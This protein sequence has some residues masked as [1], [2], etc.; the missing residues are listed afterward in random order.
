MERNSIGGS[1]PESIHGSSRNIL[2][3]VTNK[4]GSLFKGSTQ[5]SSNSSI[6]THS[7]D[8]NGPSLFASPSPIP[9]QLAPYGPGSPALPPQPF[10]SSTEPVPLQHPGHPSHASLPTLALSSGGPPSYAPSYAPQESHPNS[11]YNFPARMSS[12]DQHAQ[13]NFSDNRSIHSVQSSQSPLTTSPTEY[14]ASKLNINTSS[15]DVSSSSSISEISPMRL[16]APAFV[17]VPVPVMIQPKPPATLF[18]QGVHLLSPEGGQSSAQ[19]YAKFDQA[20]RRAPAPGQPNYNWYAHVTCLNNM[21]VA[22]RQASRFDDALS[23]IQEAW[24]VAV[25]AVVQEKRRLL[26]IGEEAGSDWMELVVDSLALDQDAIWVSAIQEHHTD[27]NDVGGGSSSGGGSS[28][29]EFHKTEPAPMD[30]ENIRILH[31]PPIVALFLD[32]TTNMGNILYNV[33]YIPESLNQHSSCLRLGESVLEA[34]PLDAEFRMSFPLSIPNRFATT[35]TGGLQSAPVAVPGEPQPAAGAVQPDPNMPAPPLNRR[36]H[37]SFL[38]RTVII[39]QARSL[40]HLAVCCQALGLDD[41][42][43]QC[44][45]HAHEI[46][47]FYRKFGI[48]GGVRDGTQVVRSEAAETPGAVVVRAKSKRIKR[49]EQ[50]RW[51]EMQT[52][53]MDVFAKDIIEPLQAGVIANLAMSFY[54][55]GRFASSMEYLV[56]SSV[57]FRKL[58]HVLAYTRVLSSIHALK[59][60]LGRSL[61][62]LHWIRNMETQASGPTEIDECSRYWGPPRIH[63]I[64]VDPSSADPDTFASASIGANWINPGLKDLKACLEI[65]KEKDDLFSVLLTLVNLAT[66]YIINGQ[67]YIALYILGSMLNEQT[68]SGLSLLKMTDDNDSSTAKMPEVLKLHTHFTLCQ[69]VFLVLRLQNGPNEE[70]FP[71]FIDIDPETLLCCYSEP[72]SALI[73]AMDLQIHN[74]LDL[75]MLCVGFVTAVQ[76]LEKT[77]DEI[78]SDISYAML[79][80]TYIGEGGYF[81]AAAR[82][83]NTLSSASQG[84]STTTDQAYLS[85]IYGI[86]TGVDFYSQQSI[87]IRMLM[88]KND[89]LNAS[90]IYRYE[91]RGRSILYYTQGAQKLD[92]TVKDALELFRR[93]SGE[94]TNASSGLISN[95]HESTIAALL[96]PPMSGDGYGSGDSYDNL[97]IDQQQVQPARTPA[98]SKFTAAMQTSM[99]TAP[100]LFAISGDIMAYG[101]FQMSVQRSRNQYSGDGI[102]ADL[103]SVLR[104]P[105]TP[106]PARIHRDLL[107]AGAAAYSGGLGMCEGC[108]RDM[109]RD[110]DSYGEL[111]FV[112]TEGAIVGATPHAGEVVFGGA[113]DPDNSILVKRGLVDLRGRH[114]FPCRHYYV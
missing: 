95:L 13:R 41:A 30:D 10:R 47:S 102:A 37:L 54:M 24:G 71:R 61:K 43:L 87:L 4:F 66:G 78:M 105:S 109:L 22:K 46:V 89:W 103:L 94:V 108:M 39:A 88:G 5:R 113:A 50:F 27:G 58:G 112:S 28:G 96:I 68:A 45:S 2:N 82:Y 19:A 55:K 104:I 42:A 99:F 62:G 17:P 20:L 63:G 8:N 36:L 34:F 48:I 93:G 57:L 21:A 3:N 85:H 100:S 7:L 72:I 97:S 69:A 67:P 14:Q 86:G 9:A 49:D 75:D 53:K 70:L 11:G 76:D 84:P 6:P 1:R 79:Y 64:N 25:G 16:H 110:P 12:I 59:I 73:E 114:M 74:F 18:E 60:D 15:D 90:N 33:G 77:R 92:T 23:R 107:A 40:T 56:R 80:I 44:N 31:G 29:S 91:T 51:Q 111:V 35:M 65:F 32:L 98:I 83:M 26:A 81:G 52:Q 38:H 101:A 106:T